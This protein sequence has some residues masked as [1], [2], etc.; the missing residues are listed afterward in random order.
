MLRV[1]SCIVYE[2]DPVFLV[3]ALVTLLFGSV[4]TMRLFA[5]VRRTDKAIRR[6]WLALAGIIGGGTIWS[7]HFVAILAYES[8]LILGY[9]PV[10]TLI[11]LFL[12]VCTTT[13]GFYIASTSRHSYR[14]ELG[15]LT[16]GLG[17][18]LMHYIGMR[19]IYLSGIYEWDTILV[20]FS[21]IFGGAFGMLATNRIGRPTTRYCHYGAACAFF[22]AV[23]MMHFTGMSG[24][25]LTPLDVELEVTRLVE[26]CPKVGDGVIRRR[27]EV[28]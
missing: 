3:L 19:A 10:L 15:G 2:H 8:N 16:L 26:L 9:E 17:I 25:T 23:G 18:G 13:L 20:V 11:S 12:V 7:T 28:A 1:L 4:V 6:L 5:R 14:I 21:I 24:F 22:L 27:F